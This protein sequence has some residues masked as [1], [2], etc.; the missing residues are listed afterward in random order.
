VRGCQEE[1]VFLKHYQIL[2]NL[3]HISDTDHV[4]LLFPSANTVVTKEADYAKK[5]LLTDAGRTRLSIVFLDEF[6]SCLEDQC[7]GS[8]LDG[9]YQ[10]FRKKYLPHQKGDQQGA[11]ADDPASS[12]PAD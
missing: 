6:V 5:Q 4:V 10:A 8:S 1:L 2:R 12:G 11:Q 9:Y 7:K 3:V